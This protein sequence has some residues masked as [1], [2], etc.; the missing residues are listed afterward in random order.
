MSPSIEARIAE[1][2]VAPTPPS[3]PPSLL[4]PWSSPLP[5]I[6][7][8]PLP[9]TPSSLHLPPPI[10]TSLPLPSSPLLPLP[11]LLFIPP[12]VDCKEEIPE[13]ELP[14]HKRLCLTAPTSRYKVG[15]SSTAAPRPTGGHK[16][17]Y[18][19]IS[20]LDAEIRRQ[21]AKEVDYGIRD[22]WVD[23]TEAVEEVAP[24]TLEG[25]NARVIELAAL[26]E[27]DT[28]DIYAVIEDDCM[29]IGSRGLVPKRLGHF[30]GSQPDDDID[31]TSLHHY[32]EVVSG[33]G[34]NSGTLG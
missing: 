13:A 8:P 9:L 5:Q 26:Q 20:T 32:R 15:E 22:V 12:P 24:T 33:I 1:Y 11:V 14:P 19:F 7:S 16:I 31:C 30:V 17:D 2:V 18:G 25:V 21:R 28:Q 3:P 6:P 23:L 27:Q 34:T 10:P 29:T 4:S